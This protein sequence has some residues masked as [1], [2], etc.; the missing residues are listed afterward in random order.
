MVN[1]VDYFFRDTEYAFS[2]QHAEE[3]GDEH[4]D[5]HE[6]EDH[7]DHGH[8]EGPTVFTNDATEFGAIFD[9]VP[10][11]NSHSAKVMVNFLEMDE[12]IVGAEAFMNL[13]LIHI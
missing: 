4:G 7:D 1:S 8:E 11:R 6:G 13:S 12:A 5:E 3:H 9:F 10:F 2:E